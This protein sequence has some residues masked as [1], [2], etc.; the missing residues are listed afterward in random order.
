VSTVILV[1]DDN[2]EFLRVVRL[3]LLEATEPFEVHTVETGEQALAF[4]R[5]HP[6]FAAAPAPSIVVLDY[7]LPDTRATSILRHM[8]ASPEL[9]H[10]PVLVLSQAG[11][12]EDAAAARA[13]GATDFR[14][15]PSRVQDLARV[16]EEFWAV[17]ANRDD[18]ADRG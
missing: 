12:M 1:A 6:P 17:H 16:I 9:M 8:R 14:V 18:P 15:K 13:A 4:L 7:R 2:R 10:L 3:V 5:R 11:W